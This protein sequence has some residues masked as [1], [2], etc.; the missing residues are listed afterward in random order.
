MRNVGMGPSMTKGTVVSAAALAALVAGGCATKLY[1]REQASRLE[2]Q[3]EDPESLHF[4]IEPLEIEELEQRIE[5]QRERIHSGADLAT[6]ALERATEAMELA[7][8]RLLFEPSF[9]VEGIFFAPG[10]TELTR[11]ARALLDQL[12]ARLVLENRGSYLEVQGHT[13]ASGSEDDNLLLG[14]RRA[15]AVRRYLHEQGGIPLHHISALSLGET[16]AAADGATHDGRDR[17]RR[18]VVLVLHWP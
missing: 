18:V 11:E 4:Q 9:S 15:E 10:S 1:V 12:A 17:D 5:P 2:A 7:A 16:A 13:D 14:Q 6:L 8:G 3:F